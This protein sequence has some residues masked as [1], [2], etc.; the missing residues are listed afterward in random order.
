LRAAQR[1]WFSLAQTNSRFGSKKENDMTT[2]NAELAAIRERL[3]SLERQNR[4]MTLAILVMGTLLGC[5]ALLA[6]AP[7][8]SKVLDGEKLLLRDKKGN[9]RCQIEVD[10][11]NGVVQTLTDDKGRVRL[12][13]ATSADGEARFTMLDDK[14]A[15]RIRLVTFP[16]DLKDAEGVARISVLGPG[17]NGIPSDKGGICIQTMKDGTTGMFLVGEDKKVNNPA[18]YGPKEP[19]D[20]SG[21]QK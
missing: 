12:K 19:R 17:S 20:G 13:M 11:D 7:D 10:K 8:Q 14:G 3:Q 1:E 4:R 18:F 21:I 16:S 15:T 5:A 2:Q 6:A 9:I